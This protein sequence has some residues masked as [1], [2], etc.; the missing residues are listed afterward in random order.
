[1]R[2][3]VLACFGSTRGLDSEFTPVSTTTAIIPSIVLIAAAWAST[4]IHLVVVE[5]I[6]RGWEFV[7]AKEGC[8]IVWLSPTDLVSGPV[9]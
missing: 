4:G 9:A 7:R 5:V 3:L 6:L 8:T 1:M 2:V